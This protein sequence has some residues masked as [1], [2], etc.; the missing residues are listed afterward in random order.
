MIEKKIPA[1]QRVEFETMSTGGDPDNLFVAVFGR[2]GTGKT[3]LMGTAPGLGVIPLQRK[4]RPTIEQVLRDLYPERKIF[5]PKNADEFYK[6][7]NP[8]AMSLMNFEEGKIF[9]RQLVDKIKRGAW[10]LLEHPEVKTIGIDDGTTLMNLFLFAHYGK[11]S[12]LHGDADVARKLYGPPKDEFKEF[13]V[14]LQAKHLV[15]TF[16]GGEAYVKNQAQGFDEPKGFKEIGFECNVLAETHYT[17]AEGFSL[18]VKMCQDRA[19]L[20]G[21]AGQKLLNGEMIEFKYLASQV[22]EWTSPDD[23]E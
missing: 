5:W 20:Q 19:S 3:R 13:L 9:H 10:S 21:E 22:R 1:G 12:K 16:Q 11:A 2:A 18:D 4:T 8:M 6:Y 14:S 17:P 7:Q 23:W 15:M